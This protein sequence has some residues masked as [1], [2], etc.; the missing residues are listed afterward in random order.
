MNITIFFVLFVAGI[1]FIGLAIGYFVLSFISMNLK[2]IEV[3]EW[4][5]KWCFIIGISLVI[6]SIVLFNYFRSSA[7]SINS[8][9]YGISKFTE[10]GDDGYY[11]FGGTYVNVLTKGEDGNLKVLS[12]P[13]DAVEYIFSDNEKPGITIYKKEYTYTFLDDF[14]VDLNLLKPND[15]GNIEKAVITI[16]KE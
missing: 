11:E 5:S 13:T 10:N 15:N 7:Y 4:V 8:Y 3:D 16:P 6:V 14:K 12:V 2:D 9:E 1:I